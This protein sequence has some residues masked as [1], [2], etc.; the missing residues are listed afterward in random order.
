[1]T[2]MTSVLTPVRAGAIALAL[3]TAGTLP[4]AAQ[5]DVDIQEV[6]SPGGQVFWLVEEPTIPI[7]SIEIGFSG[8][9]R[10][11]PADKT[12]LTN[13]TMALMNEGSGEL[14]AVAFANKADDI[15][16]RF[17]FSGGR[18][19]T[20]VSG[21]F[22]VETLDEGI[23]LLALAMGSP[24]FDAEPVARVRG[25]ILSGI[26]QDETD[27]QAIAGKE[28]AA[29]AF[30]DHAY[31]RPSS[32]TKETITAITVEDMRTAHKR[33]MTRANAHIGIVGAINA[34]KAGKIV[35]TLMAVLPEGATVTAEPRDVAPPPGVIV[36]EQDVPQ[37]TAIFGHAGLARDD[38]DFIPAFVMNRVL[39]GGGF[40]SRLM[41]EVREKRG[42]AYS[43]YS[44][45]S[46]RDEAALYLG[47]VQ[48]ANE[49]VAESI[50]VIRAEWTRMATEGMSEE[51]L[52]KAKRYL[53]GAF[54]LQFDSNAKIANYL[55]FVQMEDLGIDYINIRND[56]IEA[57][58]VED[59]KRVA[60]RVLKPDALSI[61]VVGMPVGL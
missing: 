28:W 23:D 55:I 18:D 25:Q 4:G 36:I 1:M 30:P 43:V 27:P 51:D 3:A 57:V 15:S 39:G 37:S 33:L 41:E 35:D 52:E 17:G 2:M 19:S 11:D 14:D 56:L 40:S 59:I 6:T 47:G 13:F 46:A 10:L 26:A 21:A 54:P 61:V 31:G 58:T 44:Y 16:A 32:G 20:E 48:T 22:L 9:A 38:P 29:R 34:A 53:T 45:L 12:G 50:D 60:A 24:R 49:R 5:A 8:G 7:V 42:L